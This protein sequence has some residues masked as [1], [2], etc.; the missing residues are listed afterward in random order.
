MAIPHTIIAINRQAVRP[1]GSFP[2]C[3]SFGAASSD[4]HAC[5][6]DRQMTNR[7]GVSSRIWSY[8]IWN[9]DGVN[10]QT[11]TVSSSIDNTLPVKSRCAFSIRRT[12]NATDGFCYA[13]SLT[14]G[15]IIAQATF[16]VQHM[17]VRQCGHTSCDR[18]V[19]GTIPLRQFKQ[20]VFDALQLTARHTGFRE[21]RKSGS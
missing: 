14:M 3:I 13:K 10:E 15:R 6:P 7:V 1:A 21:G 19:T 2:I 12:R 17:V 16:L 18:M 4:G 20:T 8:T 9:M 5:V 11:Y